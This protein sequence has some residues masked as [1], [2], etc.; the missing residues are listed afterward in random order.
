VEAIRPRLQ[1]EFAGMP[2]EDLVVDG[3]MLVARKSG[4]APR[5]PE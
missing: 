3:I 2:A 4:I 5:Q 1:P